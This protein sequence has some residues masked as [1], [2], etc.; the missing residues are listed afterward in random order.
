MSS[1]E[2]C[3][4]CEVDRFTCERCGAAGDA[5]TSHVKTRTGVLCGKC[6]IPPVSGARGGTTI[7]FNLRDEGE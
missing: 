3:P 6:W 2:E 4:V 7:V 1:T 5:T